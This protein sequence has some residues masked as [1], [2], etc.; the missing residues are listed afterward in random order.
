MI[1]GVGRGEDRVVKLSDVR[2]IRPDPFDIDDRD[3]FESSKEIIFV[4]ID[5]A[6]GDVPDVNIAVL[7]DIRDTW[8]KPA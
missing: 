7:I 5:W 2:C 4:N 6:L 3:I 8:A 1:L